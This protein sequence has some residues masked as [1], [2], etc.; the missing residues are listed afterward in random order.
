M[1]D[2]ARKSL[3]GGLYLAI[4]GVARDIGRNSLGIEIKNIRLEV[5]NF[6]KLLDH[7]IFRRV[8]SVMLQII[9][10]R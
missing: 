10:V 2:R 9:E 3:I 5:E 6:G 4:G 8:A 1:V 7:S